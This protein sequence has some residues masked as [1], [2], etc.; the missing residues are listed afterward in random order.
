MKS[1]VIDKQSE[2][3]YSGSNKGFE[4]EYF[5]DDLIHGWMKLTQDAYAFARSMQMHVCT[6]NS[7]LLQFNGSVMLMYAHNIILAKIRMHTCQ[8]N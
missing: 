7:Q 2:H 1:M 8:Y 3:K 4:S 5:S 6:H